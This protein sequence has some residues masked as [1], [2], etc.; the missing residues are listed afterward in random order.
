MKYDP[1]SK[2]IA[3]LSLIG[4]VGEAG[5]SQICLRNLMWLL[6]AHPQLVAHAQI[7]ENLWAHLNT[8]CFNE[9]HLNWAGEWKEEIR[10]WIDICNWIKT[11]RVRLSRRP[12]LEDFDLSKAGK[13][14]LVGAGVNRHAVSAATWSRHHSCDIYPPKKSSQKSG[15]NY[16]LL[17]SHL[18]ATYF[19]SRY[20]LSSLSFY[21][22]YDREQERPIAPSLTYPVG[23]AVRELSLQKYDTLIGQL[24]SV[25]GTDQFALAM[26][27]L[28]VEFSSLS[29]EDAG[30]AALRI[31]AI[32]RY[33]ST[34][35]RVLLGFKPA[36][37][38]RKG[39]GGGG[40][41]GHVRRHQ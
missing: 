4:A 14:P 19:E 41:G 25:I 23:L 28:A 13:H 38:F 35:T 18:L 2:S 22:N 30:L 37:S 9:S 20:K 27:K 16:F 36:Q 5:L 29:M 17:Q 34:F 8:D 1:P 31:N 40:G 21:E 32:R 3:H 24:P 39:W 15:A 7:F 33:F 11:N 10:Y 12:G 26:D 6:N